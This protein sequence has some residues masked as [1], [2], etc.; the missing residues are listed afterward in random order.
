MSL[1]RPGKWACIFTRFICLF[2]HCRERRI[3]TSCHC[4]LW[5]LAAQYPPCQLLGSTKK[6]LN[7]CEGSL[8]LA[9][10]RAYIVIFQRRIQLIVEPN[11]MLSPNLLPM[12]SRLEICMTANGRHGRGRQWKPL[13]TSSP[14]SSKAREHPHQEDNVALSCVR[15]SRAECSP[16]HLQYDVPQRNSLNSHCGKFY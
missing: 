7:N 16:E 3:R 13:P 5:H 9:H 1:L 10:M 15:G 4:H 8:L 6:C 11:N 14:L 12:L 2:P